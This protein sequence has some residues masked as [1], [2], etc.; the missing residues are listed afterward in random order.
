MLYIAKETIEDE[1][2]NLKY[3]DINQD[4]NKENTINNFTVKTWV[5]T[6]NNSKCY[7]LNVEVKNNYNEVELNT[8][9]TK[10]K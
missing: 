3:N 9:V 8:Y 2:Y 6:M 4:Y 7:K 1:R 10:K 5:T